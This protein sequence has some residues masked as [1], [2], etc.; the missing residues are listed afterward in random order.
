MKTDY[1]K[2]EQKKEQKKYTGRPR[3]WWMNQVR[4]DVYRSDELQNM[5]G[6]TM[7]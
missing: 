3:K 6:Q 1:S 2:W 4:I 5:E 7:M